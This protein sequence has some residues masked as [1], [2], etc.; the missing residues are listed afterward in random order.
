MKDDYDE[1]NHKI[2]LHAF[3]VCLSFLTLGLIGGGLIFFL[4]PNDIFCNVTTNKYLCNKKICNKGYFG[5]DCLECKI[6]D[7]GYCD[8]S[9][10][11]SGSGKCICNEGWTGKLCDNCDIGYF[12]IN[13]TK[14][15]DCIKSKKLLE[16]DLF[17][18]NDKRS[19]KFVKNLEKAEKK[20]FDCN[21]ICKYMDKEMKPDMNNLD[22][23]QARYPSICLNDEEGNKRVFR[24]MNSYRN[25]MLEQLENYDLNFE[26]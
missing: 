25:K 20:C 16:Q 13:C 7:N 15:N 23:Y 2:K 6:C 8:G 24:L 17:D 3:F 10:T 1:K 22:I 26:N 9:G 12:G 4:Y 21:K 18:K 11:N 19:R 5:K 14:C